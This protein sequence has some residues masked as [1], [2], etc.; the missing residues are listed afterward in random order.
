[1][2]QSELR[3]RKTKRGDDT[4]KCNEKAGSTT[5][6]PRFSSRIRKKV[7]KVK[8]KVRSGTSKQIASKRRILEIY[9]HNTIQI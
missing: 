3:M 5:W 4:R 1:M 8:K 9:T 6:P 2:L 7:W